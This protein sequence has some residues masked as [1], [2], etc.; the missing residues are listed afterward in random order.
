M[1][2][3]TR[4]AHAT[5]VGDEPGRQAARAHFL[6]LLDVEFAEWPE[7]SMKYSPSRPTDRPDSVSGDSVGG[8]DAT[9]RRVRSS[10]RSAEWGGTARARRYAGQNTFMPL[11]T[12]KQI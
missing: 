8:A 4:L 5:I 7:T 6:S 1:A 12:E 11:G 3:V 2:R 10:S 9:A